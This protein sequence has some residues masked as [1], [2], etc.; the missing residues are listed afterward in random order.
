MSALTSM[1][2]KTV[3]VEIPDRISDDRGGWILIYENAGT[4]AGRI[5]PTSSNERVVADA[6]QQQITHVLYTATLTTSTGETLGR[7]ARVTVEDLVVEVLGV[8][9]PSKAAHHYEIDCLERQLDV[10]DTY[11]S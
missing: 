8:R 6:E 11:G 9:E 3:T 5:C 4:L 10:I 7:G 1:L 2:N